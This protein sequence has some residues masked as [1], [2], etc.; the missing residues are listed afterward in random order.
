MHTVHGNG[1]KFQCGVD[2][3]G[4]GP[5]I[6]PMVISIVCGDR[7]ILHETGS[8]DSKLLSPSRREEVSVL[9]KKKAEF[10]R[11]LEISAERLNSLMVEKTLNQIEADAVSELL[12]EAKYE[13]YVDC[14]DVNEER[15]SATLSVNAPVRVNCIHGADHFIPAVSAASVISKVTR[16]RRMREIEKEYGKMGSGYPSDPRTVSF[17]EEA[18]KSRKNID[19]I[20]RTKWKTYTEMKKRIEQKDIYGF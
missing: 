5:V 1:E 18:L 12:S 13:A 2:E 3:A 11:S 9:V 10:W 7:D 17:L 19:G 4:R 15:G 6:G 16:D 14:F 20:V 8:R